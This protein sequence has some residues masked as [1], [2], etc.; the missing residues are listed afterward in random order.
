MLTRHLTG[1]LGTASLLLAIAGTGLRC[2][3]SDDSSAQPTNPGS[4][5]SADG[6]NPRNLDGAVFDVDNGSDAGPWVPSPL[7][8]ACTQ[9]S[10]CG[11][12]GLCWTETSDVFVPGS[13]AGGFCTKPCTQDSECGTQGLCTNVIDDKQRFCLLKCSF[14]TGKSDLDTI[15]RE[16]STKCQGRKNSACVPVLQNAADGTQAY[17][18]FDVCIPQCSITA[19][20]CAANRTCDTG[21][22][23]CVESLD[24]TLLENGEAC[25]YDP[26]I[27]NRQCRG[28][29]FLI[30]PSSDTTVPA[31]RRLAGICMDP[32]TFGTAESCNA[33]GKVGVCISTAVFAPPNKSAVS[34]DLSVCMKLVPKDNDCG[35]LWR[36]RQFATFYEGLG[37]SMCQWAFP[38]QDDLDCA[39]QCQKDED[40]RTSTETASTCDSRKRCKRG[41]GSPFTASPTF[42]CRN[43]PAINGKYCADHDVESSLASCK[44]TDGGLPDA[45][46]LDAASPDA[47]PPDAGTDAGHSDPPLIQ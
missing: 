5:A 36:D 23:V 8:K 12:D 44:T 31:D 25:S 14:G 32:C 43:V 10:E 3:S 9:N 40:C 26:A 11:E 18:G 33:G 35:C 28:R 47:A 45:A 7:A 42:S 22:G 39:Y 46:S 38:C 34:N 24:S 27:T 30:H 13:P 41:D 15:D 37:T 21:R 16:P 6:G 1:F 19:G 2:K 20:K 17:T 4:D 29:C